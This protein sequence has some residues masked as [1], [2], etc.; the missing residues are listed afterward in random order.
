MQPGDVVETY[1]DISKLFNLTGFKPKT[2]IKDGL[3]EFFNW[4]K[5]YFYK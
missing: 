1:A 4:Y 3:K 5:R 2:D